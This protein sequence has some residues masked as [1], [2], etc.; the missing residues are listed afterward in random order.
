MG[1]KEIVADG[2]SGYVVKPE[3]DQLAESI[4]DF[5]NNKRKS[6][7][8]EG[9]RAGKERFSWDKMTLSILDVY[10]KITGKQ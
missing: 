3:P 6:I 2:K 7:F 10:R 8:I 4:I 5:Y 1:L 9:V